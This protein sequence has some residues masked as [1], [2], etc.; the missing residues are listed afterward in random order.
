MLCMLL[1]VGAVAGELTDIS[2]HWAADT[3]AK[4]ADAGYI[5][6]YPDGTFKP[7][8][9]ITRA[10][11]VTLVNKAFNMTAKA[12]IDFTDVPAG[13]WYY[14]EV[15]KAKAAGYIGGYPDNT[16]RPD[17]PISRQKVAIVLLKLKG[18]TA[19]TGAAA[20]FKDAGLIPDWSRG[21]VGAV[22]GAGY[23][24][25]YPDGTFRPVNNITRAEAVV[26]LD[27]VLSTLPEVPQEPEAPEPV[28][29]P[30]EVPDE[31][32]GP[33]PGSG[34]SSG[35]GG[36]GGGGSGGSSDVKV[37]SISV[38]PAGGVTAIKAGET[39][40]FSA[41]VAPENATNKKVEWSVEPETGSAT[42][43]PTGLLKATGAGTVIVK[44]T[45]QDGSGVTGTYRIT[46]TALD[47]ESDP[48]EILY[49][50]SGGMMPTVDVKVRR[51]GTFINEY[52]LYF[53][54]EAVGSTSNGVITIPS[55]VLNDLTRVKVV[56]GS[57]MWPVID[58]GSW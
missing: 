9:S 11:F 3:I 12:E 10:E 58:G 50:A 54:G 32:P 35:G 22:A 6:G 23:M 36:S 46:I 43:S 13:A 31:E 45:A 5:G 24:S 15:A 48:V 16:M 30:V 34:G 2:N 29:E 20:K 33:A 57:S 40:L 4:W 42:I 47:Q 38:L 7:D 19:D 39:L 25:G 14:G 56:I 1:P 49:R 8:N 18:L 44:A 52:S 26:T 53:D 17:N 37:T 41:V 21:D 55:N 27:N 51:A 28:I